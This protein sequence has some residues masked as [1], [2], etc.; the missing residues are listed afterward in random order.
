MEK[1]AMEFAMPA[2]RKGLR[3]AV[4]VNGRFA[5]YV[6]VVGRNRLTF[7]MLPAARLLCRHLTD[8]KHALRDLDQ[9]RVSK[10]HSLWKQTDC[11]RTFEHGG[12]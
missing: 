3:R 7:C 5:V 11:S 12:K 8:G 1:T 9:A 6:T 4:S 10:H 2:I